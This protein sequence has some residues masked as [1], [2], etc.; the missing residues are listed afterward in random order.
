MPPDLFRFVCFIV[1]AMRLSTRLRQPLRAATQ[2]RFTRAM[3]LM[4]RC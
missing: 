4:L 2:L 3:L 1:Y